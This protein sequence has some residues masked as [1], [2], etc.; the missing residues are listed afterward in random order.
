[1]HNEFDTKL[2]EALTLL[3]EGESL[4]TVSARYPEYTDELS[5]YQTLLSLVGEVSHVT[6]SES[7]LRSALAQMGSLTMPATPM[8]PVQ[9][10]Y[11]AYFM[12]YRN[13]LVLPALVLVLIGGGVLVYPSYQT[14]EP[15]PEAGLTEDVSN[16]SVVANEAA[17]G[18]A[19]NE[20]VAMQKTSAPEARTMM[21]SSEPNVDPELQEVFAYSEESSASRSTAEEA[22]AKEALNDSNG[23]EPFSNTYDNTF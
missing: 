10:P 12:M 4:S 8:A 20:Q 9:S 17:G 19:P 3:L 21:M 7:G 11:L 1:M 16:G 2:E 6:P 23:V 5:E 18:T 13:V 14:G 15:A 22:A